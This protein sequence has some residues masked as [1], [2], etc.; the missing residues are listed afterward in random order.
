[1]GLENFNNIILGIE[2]FDFAAEQ[3]SAIEAN[4]DELVLMQQQ[5][6]AAGTDID[7]NSRVDSYTPQYARMKMRKFVGLGAAIDRVTFYAY[8]GMYDMLRLI[9]TGDQFTIGNDFIGVQG[10]IERIGELNYGI[11]PE[12]RLKFAEEYVLPAVLQSFQTKVFGQY[13]SI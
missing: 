4:A 1:M 6:L 13:E 3:L 9:V 2:N 11:D 10:M 8:G 12:N 7:G 5:Q